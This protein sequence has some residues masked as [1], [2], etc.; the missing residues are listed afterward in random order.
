[1]IRV[2]RATARL[3]AFALAVVLVVVCLT[4]AVDGFQIA[5][6][7]NP[8]T[9]L[10]HPYGDMW[11]AATGAGYSTDTLIVRRDLNRNGS[12][13]PWSEVCPISEVWVSYHGT[14][15]AVALD[16]LRLR[17]SYR[18]GSDAG[19]GATADTTGVVLASNIVGTKEWRIPVRCTYALVKCYTA[20]SAAYKPWHVIAFANPSGPN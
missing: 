5:M 6:K 19:T 20:G 3:L 10:G 18:V 4:A 13:R 12:T 16:S 15:G 8:V 7:I 11:N 2:W 14:A 1:M 17:F 9:P